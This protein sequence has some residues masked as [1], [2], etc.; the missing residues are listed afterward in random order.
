M[1]RI[2]SRCALRYCS[3]LQRCEAPALA[4]TRGTIVLSAQAPTATVA[5][6]NKRHSASCIK[7]KEIFTSIRLYQIQDEKHSKH[8]R[9]KMIQLH[10]A[11]RGTV[12]P[13][14]RKRQTTQF[15]PVVA[16]ISNAV[17]P[18]NPTPPS[19]PCQSLVQRRQKTKQGSL[20]IFLLFLR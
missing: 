2:I 5:R 18:P 15:P 16:L 14:L 7:W 12:S 6:Y 11:V 13:T 10:L 1:P 9:R 17:S 8:L 20:L 4:E 19:A 3:I